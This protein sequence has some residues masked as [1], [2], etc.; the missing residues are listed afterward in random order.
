MT[1]SSTLLAGDSV[2]GQITR[3]QRAE[4]AELLLPN[5]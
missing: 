5:A 3:Q 4:V 1:S 2:I